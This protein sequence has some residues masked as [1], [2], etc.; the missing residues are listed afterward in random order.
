MV[1]NNIKVTQVNG[2]EH[3]E[4]QNFVEPECSFHLFSCPT[5]QEIP[6]MSPFP[7]ELLSPIK[8]KTEDTF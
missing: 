8:R 4:N 2:S 3:L 5:P 6:F 7:G 1:Y